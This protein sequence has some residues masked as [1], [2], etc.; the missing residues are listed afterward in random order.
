MLAPMTEIPEEQQAAA[1]RAV[2]AAADARDQ[3]QAELDARTKELADAAVEA[4]RLGAV[5]TRIRQYAKVS[6]K[7]YYLWLAAAGIDVRGGG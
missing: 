6:S 3:A 1:L 5:R 7:T 2:V 4:T